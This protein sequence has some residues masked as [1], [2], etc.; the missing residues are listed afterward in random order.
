MQAK[1]DVSEGITSHP[2]AVLASPHRD[3]R[4]ESIYSSPAMR[5]SVLAEE[6]TNFP[7]NVLKVTE[8]AG[9]AAHP[10]S[11]LTTIHRKSQGG[12]AITHV[13]SLLTE[14]GSPPTTPAR[15][16]AESSY[17][18]SSPREF[19]SQ[20]ARS[21]RHNKSES[22]PSSR[23]S[24]FSSPPAS[25]LHATSALLSPPSS[26]RADAVGALLTSDDFAS[27]FQGLPID[28]RAT[29]SGHFIDGEASVP[30]P[31]MVLDGWA[32]T[33]GDE[34]GVGLLGN[35]RHILEFDVDFDELQLMVP[36]IGTKP[37]CCRRLM[38]LFISLTLT[39][40]VP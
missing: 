10:F 25:G 1:E 4:L 37:S 40:I 16:L 20:R 2:S 22:P 38:R 32:E 36:P 30:S 6:I 33:N 23:G 7:H 21:G 24:R 26:R 14:F 5:Q 17:L 15:R 34:D 29:C 3:S 31:G 12:I 27:A 11:P 8:R 19:F 35:I 18:P 9:R 13:K 39:V 28:A